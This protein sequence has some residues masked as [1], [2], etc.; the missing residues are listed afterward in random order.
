MASKVQAAEP[1]AHIHAVR[2][3]ISPWTQEAAGGRARG[4][5]IEHFMREFAGQGGGVVAGGGSILSYAQSADG[6]GCWSVCVCGCADGCGAVSGGGVG[7]G[8]G[9]TA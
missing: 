8:A 6:F 9:W 7:E 3:I 1:T 2:R 5:R 4:E